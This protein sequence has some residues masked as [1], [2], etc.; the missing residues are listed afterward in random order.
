MDTYLLLRAHAEASGGKEFFVDLESLG[1][2]LG[3][4]SR[5]NDIDLRR[6]AIRALKELR[7]RYR[8]V[9]PF[10]FHGRDARVIMTD[11]PGK[12]FLISSDIVRPD[13]RLKHSVR[14]KFLRLITAYLASKGEDVTKIA[15]AQLA[16]RFGCSDWTI[17]E[18]RKELK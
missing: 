4:P 6:Q 7:G 8:L 12:V 5:W 14:V 10:F 13:L 2:S 9:K 17:S 11:I 3:L 18:A 1:L 15:D 16:R